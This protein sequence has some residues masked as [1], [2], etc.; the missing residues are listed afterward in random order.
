[1]FP[2]SLGEY[3]KVAFFSTYG[4]PLRSTDYL[5]AISGNGHFDLFCLVDG[6]PY[7]VVNWTEV[8]SV[9]QG[10]STNHLRL[11]ADGATISM[12]ANGELLATVPD[13][14]FRR[15]DIGLMAGSFEEG[16][17]EIAFDNLKVAEIEEG[18]AP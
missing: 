18:S 11:F 6:Q 3:D 14:T 8:P 16:G 4:R 15:G 12:Y 5:F 9:E 17:V 10:Q 2:H 1:L 13:N 7:N